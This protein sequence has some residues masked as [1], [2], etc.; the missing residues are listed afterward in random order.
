MKNY[1][2]F[3]I[4]LVSSSLF[5]CGYSPFGEDVRYCLFKPTYF[6]YGNYKMF[7]YNADIFGHENEAT[8]SDGK[9]TYQA[10]EL[11]WYNYV[12]KKVP[13][14]TIRTFMNTATFSDV[15]EDS[16]NS[17]LEYLYANKMRDAIR[18]LTIAKKCETGNSVYIDN[19]V[20][21]RGVQH[22]SKSANLLDEVV[23]LYN[24]ERNQYFKKKYAFL[25]IRLGYYAG[26]EDVVKEIF[27][28]QFKN[29]DKDYLYYWS[30]FFYTFSNKSA[31]RMNDVAALLENAPEKYYASFY[32]FKD[33]FDLQEAL[34]FARTK[35]DIANLYGYASVQKVNQ[36]LDYLKE[37]YNNNPKSKLLSFL[38]LR[39][40][41]KIED[42]VYTPYYTNY[43]PSVQSV[44]GYYIDS[45]EKNT[46]NT[47][48]LR[49]ESDRIYAQEVLNFIQSI[50]IENVE[51][52]VL[53]KASEIQ[54]LF[55]TRNYE[56][57]ILK[58]NQF[59]KNHQSAEVWQQIEKIKA[60]CLTSNQPFGNAIIKPE[61]EKI[62]QKNKKDQR[63]IFALGRE[64]EFRGNITDGI[65]LLSLCNSRDYYSAS[66]VEWRG[67]RL[68]NSN[69]MEVFYGYFD[70]LDYVYDAN[71]LQKVINNFPA[72]NQTDFQKF[73]YQKLNEDA[74]YLKDLLGTKYIREERLREALVT[75]RGIPGQ[76]WQDNYNAWERGKYD[77]MYSF[78]QNPFYKIKYTEPFIENKNPFLVNKLSVT[79]NLVKYLELANNPA[80]KNADYYY[81]LVANCYYN[82]SDSGNSWMMRRYSSYTS[83]ET[84]YTNESYIDE[85]EYRQNLKAQEYYRLA[86]ENAK[87]D[88]FKALCLRMIDFADSNYPNK[89]SLVKNEF[90][91]YYKDLS[92]CDNLNNY[93]MARR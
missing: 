22:S 63:F 33:K 15:H 77:D 71:E 4:L 24:A 72:K 75:F 58:I 70:Y 28:N 26:K 93:F 41:N 45:E 13:L 49:S 10:N 31:D 5:A 46:T 44:G 2:L 34:K 42:W 25:A 84:D 92:S 37:M 23:K 14:E 39:E 76:Y 29:A 61:V 86:Y 47:L 21:E 9:T 67:R 7:Y 27:E 16:G 20:W 11:D 8:S 79:E 74:N 69:Y 65:A 85:R 48:R 90:P 53:W 32:Y 40:I 59:Q 12:N 50:A 91:N 66:D 56:G 60:L 62:I 3:S 68:K 30:S 73:L 51:N 43:L 19:D 36:N 6:N 57:C 80:E 88:K 17:F 82:M 1:L 55:I 64:L 35:E 52:S 83:Y 78:D 87:T 54:L 38:L 18:Y 89:F 81:F